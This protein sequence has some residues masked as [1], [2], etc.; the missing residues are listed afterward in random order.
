MRKG[1]NTFKGKGVAIV[2]PFKKSGAIDFDSYEKILNHTIGGG[3]DF[4]VA[5]GTTGESATITK[6]EKKALI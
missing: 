5:L 4:I 1:Y 6:H 3:V 2:T